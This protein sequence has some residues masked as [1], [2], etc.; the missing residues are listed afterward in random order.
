[1]SFLSDAQNNHFRSYDTEIDICE[2]SG[3]Q[4]KHV[5]NDDDDYLVISG[6]KY[7]NSAKQ[8]EDLVLIRFHIGTQIL[9][10]CQTYS[11]VLALIGLFFILIC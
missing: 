6:P 4:L 5:L 3:G 2:L 1:M 8:S 9:Q 7:C 10:Q 11:E